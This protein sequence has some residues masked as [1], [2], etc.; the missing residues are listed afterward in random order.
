MAGITFTGHNQAGG[1]E[2]LARALIERAL[3]RIERAADLT[4]KDATDG[5][6]QN[7]QNRHGNRQGKARS[8]SL[9]DPSSYTGESEQRE[10]GVLMRF[11]VEGDGPFLAKFNS[12]NYGSRAHTIPV[13]TDKRGRAF[14][15]NLEY[16]GDSGKPF[17]TARAVEHPGTTGSHFWTDAIEDALRNFRLHL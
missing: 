2:R 5:I 8:K 6:V 17:A 16:T 4:I 14:A 10:S 7:A 11:R 15:G 9:S 3:P 13:G 12:I 1:F